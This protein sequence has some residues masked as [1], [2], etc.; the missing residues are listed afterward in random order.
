MFA[1]SMPTEQ[2]MLHLDL[3]LNQMVVVVVFLLIGDKAERELLLLLNS[4]LM[5]P[6]GYVAA[7]ACML[8][9]ASCFSLYR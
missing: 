9:I 5:Q 2:K 7:V 6:V 3:M 8:D 4:L 1:N